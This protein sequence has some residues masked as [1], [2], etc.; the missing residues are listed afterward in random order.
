MSDIKDNNET[1]AKELQKLRNQTHEGIE[2]PEP[3]DL[4]LV[5][6]ELTFDPADWG[7]LEEVYVE[8]V[9]IRWERYFENRE[10]VEWNN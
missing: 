9:C 5:Q 3:L 2:L 4:R 7:Y 1:V 10:C 6:E 8:P